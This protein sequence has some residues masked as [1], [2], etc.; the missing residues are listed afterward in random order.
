MHPLFHCSVTVLAPFKIGASSEQDID[1]LPVKRV[2]STASIIR[3]C[4]PLSPIEKVNLQTLGNVL[5]YADIIEQ[6]LIKK[7]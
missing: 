6:S 3:T 5:V 1:I 4:N 2:N 7:S